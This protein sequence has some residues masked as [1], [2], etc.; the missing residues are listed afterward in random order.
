MWNYLQSIPSFVLTGKPLEVDDLRDMIRRTKSCGL[1]TDFLDYVSGDYSAATDNLKILY[2]KES[3]ECV[4]RKLNFSEEE[5]EIFRS[6]LYEQTIH[7]PKSSG[8]KPAQ[9]TTGQLMGSVLSFPH[10]CALN[11]IGYWM[12]LEEFT[13][14]TF[15]LKSLPVLVNGDDILFASNPQFYELWKGNITELGFELSIGKNYIHK[16]FLMVNSEPYW[17]SEGSLDP[18][19]FLNCG[20]LTGQ[21]KVSGRESSK[22]KP[23]WDYYNKVLQGSCN[24]AYM[25]HRFVELN[26]E[27]LNSYT[28]D[29]QYNMFIDP[30]LGGLGFT[31]FDEVK[32][33]V[34]FTSFQR[35]FGNYLYRKLSTY[36][37]D[38]NDIETHMGIVSSTLSTN[39]QV[40]RK[41]YGHYELRSF[42]NVGTVVEPL[43]S[44]LIDEDERVPSDKTVQLPLLSKEVVEVKTKIVHPNRRVLRDFRQAKKLKTTIQ[45]LLAVPRVYVERVP[46]LDILGPTM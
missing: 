3:N 10:L 32:P 19:R 24:R 11:I 42:H 36:D 41:H 22:T 15:S 40:M 26:R 43:Y 31:L 23:I 14:R 45:H 44:L 13:G 35:K 34:Y 17:L 6:V 20:L 21:A 9:Q 18:V 37:G 5:K 27:A 4:M 16:N 1:P 12:T 7:Y 29:G 30:M 25:H 8:L 33:F 46:V 39:R 38:L 28:Q 2:T